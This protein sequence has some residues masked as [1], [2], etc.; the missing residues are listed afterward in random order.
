MIVLNFSSARISV[1]DGSLVVITALALN[2][3]IRLSLL[4]III[5]L[6]GKS[7]IHKKCIILWF[8]QVY[9]LV[10][11]FILRQHFFREIFRFIQIQTFPGSEN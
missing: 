10:P 6:K 7:Y 5:R 9:Y 1:S 8:L 4:Y 2:K 11:F 3:D